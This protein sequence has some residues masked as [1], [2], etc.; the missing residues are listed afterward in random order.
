MAKKNRMRFGCKCHVLLLTIWTTMYEGFYGYNQN[1]WETQLLYFFAS[2][3][4]RGCY[5]IVKNIK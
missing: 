3:K 5:Q 4:Y 1:H 2:F